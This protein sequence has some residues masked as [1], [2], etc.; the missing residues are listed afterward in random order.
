MLLH[1][2]VFYLTRT[3]IFL[4]LFFHLSETFQTG[5]FY[6]FQTVLIRNSFVKYENVSKNNARIS[7]EC[8]LFVCKIYV[9]IKTAQLKWVGKGILPP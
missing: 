1:K 6:S 8:V 4:Y 3:G 5:A 9:T 2:G 7:K